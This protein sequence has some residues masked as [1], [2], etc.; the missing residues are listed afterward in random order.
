MQH[1]RTCLSSDLN[2][3]VYR[4]RSLRKNAAACATGI[5]ALRGPRFSRSISRCR[6]AA[7]SD[8][9]IFRS[10]LIGVPEQKLEE[11]RGGVRYGD[12]RLAWPEILEK[13]FQ[14]QGCSIIGRAYLQI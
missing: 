8:V 2:S 5:S 7:S 4:N 13:Y 9:P 14:M 11:E 3:S 10:E 12:Q 6:D 1:H